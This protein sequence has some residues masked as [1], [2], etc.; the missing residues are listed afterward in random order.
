MSEV[1]SQEAREAIEA[2]S[3]REALKKIVRY[4][5]VSAPAI[6]LLLAASSKPALA[7]ISTV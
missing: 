7:A 2:R 6:T 3:R 5:A 1:K 4:G